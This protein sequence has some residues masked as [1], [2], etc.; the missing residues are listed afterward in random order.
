MNNKTWTNEEIQFLIDNNKIK[1][2]KEIAM[3]LGRTLGSVQKKIHTM[4]LKKYSDIEIGTV[5]G[6]LTV[7]KKTDTVKNGN[8]VYLCKC[9]CGNEK[10]II[11]GSLISGSTTS[12]R[13]L[14]KETVGNAVRLLPGESAFNLLYQKCK[15]GAKKRKIDFGLSKEEH[16]NLII[17]SCIYCN[18]SPQL[19]NMFLKKDNSRKQ[20]SHDI[21]DEWLSKS[22]ININTIDRVDND[23]GYYV[24]NCVTACWPCNRMKSSLSKKEFLEHVESI[25]SFQNGK[26]K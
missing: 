18:K 6:K 26:D 11:K 15:S 7:I 23:L 3:L 8:I 17:K 10:E 2:Q 24:D 12:C 19:F 1:K 21:T 13:C 16:R 14:F 4:K 22:W 25:F 20:A 5:F 9:E